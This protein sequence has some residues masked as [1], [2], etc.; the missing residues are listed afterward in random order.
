V[1]EY[2]SN[3]P[4]LFRV[5]AEVLEGVWERRELHDY[6]GDL[7]PPYTLTEVCHAA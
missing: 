2:C 5:P 4:V 7:T 3:R 6:L 1:V